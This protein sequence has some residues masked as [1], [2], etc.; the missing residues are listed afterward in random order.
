MEQGGQSAEIRYKSLPVYGTFKA[1][2]GGDRVRG[3][4]GLGVGFH[5]SRLE[6][7]SGG[8]YRIQTSTGFALGVPL[9]AV[10]FLGNKVFLN[11][12][13]ALNVLGDSFYDSNVTGMA[14]FGMGFKLADW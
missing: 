3:Y 9:G 12:N 11:G 1:W 2:F 13:A 7:S 14:N 10:L 8:D 5:T 4:V 6:T